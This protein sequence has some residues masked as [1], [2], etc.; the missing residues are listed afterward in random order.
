VLEKKKKDK[1]IRNELRQGLNG[2]D[3][4]FRI[5]TSK[6]YHLY[7]KVKLQP[8]EKLNEYTFLQIHSEEHPLLRMVVE[9]ERK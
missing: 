9:K 3:D 7:A 6:I 5:D 4:G 1:K 8:I 2:K